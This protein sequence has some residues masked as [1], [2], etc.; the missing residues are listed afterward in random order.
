[1]YYVYILQL[2]GNRS[3]VGSTPNLKARLAEHKRGESKYTSKFLP[4]EIVA[5]TCF[6]DRLTALRFERYLKTGSGKA[7]RKKRFGI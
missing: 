5:Y 7:F 6:A 2:K 1:M 4:F 3:Y